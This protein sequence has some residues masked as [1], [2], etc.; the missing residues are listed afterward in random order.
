MPTSAPTIHEARDDHP[1]RHGNAPRPDVQPSS[2]AC[3][4]VIIWM[5]VAPR[6]A[7][8]P[9][10]PLPPAPARGQAPRR[11]PTR[12]YLVFPKTAEGAPTVLTDTESG[13]A[14]G[15]RHPRPRITQVP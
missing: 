10:P 11:P 12:G 15:S 5:G 3:H 9:I 14:P 7:A 4:R 13:G 1:G 2:P 8:P 6:T